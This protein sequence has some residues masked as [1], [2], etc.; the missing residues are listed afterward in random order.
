MKKMLLNT[1][2]LNNPILVE[3]LSNAMVSGKLQ[4]GI[5]LKHRIGGERYDSITYIYGPSGMPKNNSY[6]EKF[7]DRGIN[8][9]MDA[10]DPMMVHF[11]AEQM[12]GNSITTR[13]DGSDFEVITGSKYNDSEKSAYI[14]RNKVIKAD[15]TCKNGYIHQLEDVLV[16]PGNVA[17]VIRN[18]GQSNYFSRMLDRFCA[19]FYDGALTSRYNDYAQ[20]YGKQFIDSIYEMRYFS[21]RSQGSKA[22]DLDPNNQPFP[23]LLSF[24]PGWNAYY[25]QGGNELADLAA[26]FV[27][28]DEAIKKYFLPGGSGA[29]LIEQF[30]TQENTEANLNENI[31]SIP[32][33]IIVAFLNNLMKSSFVNT[34]PSKFGDIMDDA[35]DPM[36]L[37]IDV[38]NRDANGSYDVKIANNGVIYMLNTVFAPNQ[39]VA[40]SAPAFL[41]TNMR[42]MNTAIQ[43]GSS[44]MG[45]PLG[46]SMNYYAYLL[47]MSANYGLF[48]PTDEAFGKYY[49]DP[50]MLKS[51]QPRALRFYYD[52]KRSPYVFCSS[53]KYD[54][55][56]GEVG[57][58]PTDSI[59]RLTKDKFKSQLKDILN[60]HTVVLNDGEVMGTNLYYKTKHGGE[61]KYQ[62]GTV[63][64]GGQID[65][66]LPVSNVLS[67]YHQK[68]GTA[69]A[70]D[71]LIQ[72][73]QKS[74][75]AVLREH[76]QFSEYVR[77]LDGFGNDEL[78]WFAS[79]R[80]R[81]KNSLTKKTR[82]DGYLIFVDEAGHYG[83]DYDVK[84]FNSYN[85]TVYV[86]DNE[87]MQK[88]Y[89][90]GLPSWDNIQE[91]YDEYAEEWS[92]TS[93]N[94]S[95]ALQ[96]ARD[97]ALAMIEEINAF[98]RYNFQDNSVYADK[99]IDG[100]V[101]GTACSDTLGIREKL[102]VGG[103]GDVL[104]VTDNRGNNIAVNANSGKVVNQMARDYVF[105][106]KADAVNSKSGKPEE[107]SIT[108]S[109]FAVV[110]QISSPLN[111]HRDTDRYDGLWSGT[112]AKKKLSAF[113]RLYDSRLYQK[114]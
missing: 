4:Q 82:R 95:P 8:L 92:Q 31:D 14:F 49:I 26:V 107:K 102:T 56:T 68:N 80:M 15:V 75:Y 5:V 112:Q 64:S 52:A 34:V 104:T 19:P 101:Y 108:T 51:P 33:N 40:V 55:T 39:Y 111:Y 100:G 35:S 106:L 84:F 20:A 42:I 110:H 50:T 94:P 37:T 90:L 67:T 65:E 83:L 18:N 16:P 28:T 32:G 74:V 22:L 12:I 47:A 7:Y 96:A 58:E 69:F 53:W 85:Y 44:T 97:K 23:N 93:S 73:P 79:D 66:G 88:A 77:L 21:Q 9:V 81:E 1:S 60:Y 98:V 59:E 89:N 91:I 36:G 43:D 72:A 27:P 71:H 45:T 38:I 13:G 113:R 17:E 109:S 103:S 70:I 3:M 76:E 10:T 57:T 48:I 114:Y 11:T 41:S 29:F 2:M 78:F 6:W 63:M 62:N 54:P 87:A 99:V 46:Y 30:G 86:P 25:K 105:S 61:V 24:D